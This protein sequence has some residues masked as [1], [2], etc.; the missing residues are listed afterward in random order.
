VRVKLLDCEIRDGYIHIFVELPSVQYYGIYCNIV[1][2]YLHIENFEIFIL[3]IIQLPPVI[4]FILKV[5][6]YIEFM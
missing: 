6:I 2:V 3:W 1:R 4:T 5:K